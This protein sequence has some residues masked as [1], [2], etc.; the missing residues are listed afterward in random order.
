MKCV[1]VV[2]MPLDNFSSIEDVF[3]PKK[4]ILH[5]SKKKTNTYSKI[6]EMRIREGFEMEEV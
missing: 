3:Q 4:Y 6:N 1:A 5:Q 2:G